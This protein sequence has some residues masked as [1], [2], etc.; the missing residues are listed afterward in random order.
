MAKKKGSVTSW[1]KPDIERGEAV[2]RIPAD[3]TRDM[4]LVGGEV[5][6]VTFEHERFV[7]ERVY[8]L[9]GDGELSLCELCVTQCEHSAKGNPRHTVTKCD[10]YK[11]DMAGI[12]C[13]YCGT[14]SWTDMCFQ[15]EDNEIGVAEEPNT[16]FCCNTQ[17]C[18]TVVDAEGKVLQ[19]GTGHGNY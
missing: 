5:M 11:T 2:F 15:T 18:G 8:W 17:G 13:P 7:L 4:E 10:K 12:K 3:I 9:E 6:T 1:I 16:M 19:M 14:N